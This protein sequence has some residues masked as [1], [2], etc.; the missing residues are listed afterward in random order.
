[1][2]RQGDR[3]GKSRDRFSSRGLQTNFQL[4]CFPSLPPTYL[5]HFNSQYNLNESVG[6]SFPLNP[7]PLQHST[8]AVINVILLKF[9]T[10]GEE[11][12]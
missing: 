11:L 10:M 12:S 7:P 2:R 5:M 3:E 1:M 8:M 9:C 6:S 4:A